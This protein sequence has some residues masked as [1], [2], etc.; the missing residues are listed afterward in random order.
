MLRGEPGIYYRDL[1]PL[2]CF[3]P[4]YTSGADKGADNLHT[5]LWDESLQGKVRRPIL[6]RTKSTG[7]LEQSRSEGCF[8][9]EENEFD[10]FNPEEVLPQIK[11]EGVI[12]R[13][14]RNR[15]RPTIYDYVP[16]LVILKPLIAIIKYP[17]N[18][19]RQ[20]DGEIP[21]RGIWG[22]KKRPAIVN[23]NV[24]F[25]IALYLSSYFAWLQK[26]GLVPSSVASA[27]ITNI[28][29]LHDLIA[30]MNRIRNTPIPF[31]YQ[32]H[33]RMSMWWAWVFSLTSPCSLFLMCGIFVRKVV[34]VLS[35]C[36]WYRREVMI[37]KLTRRRL[38]QVPSVLC[39]RVLY[40]PVRSY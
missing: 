3:L 17:I 4:K 39:F 1:Y 13:R 24:P 33:L 34:L 11:P 36:M 15:P 2:V 6:R 20:E 19:L 16:P 12:L 22:R 31:A 14:A 40:H 28:N 32:A 23:S 29:M 7:D 8:Q 5:P 27:L 18:K 37:L 10:G 30:N 35:P 9:F 25:E 21:D 38:V 26:Q